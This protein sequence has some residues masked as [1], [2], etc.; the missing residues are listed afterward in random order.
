M[1]D[2]NCKTVF[3]DGVTVHG[4]PLVNVDTGD[5]CSSRSRGGQERDAPSTA[6]P[7]KGVLC[8]AKAVI[9]NIKELPGKDLDVMTDTPSKL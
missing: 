3:A 2:S 1:N 9:S 7:K 5:T 4:Q 8:Y 6:A